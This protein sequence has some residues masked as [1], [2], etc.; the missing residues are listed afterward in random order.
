MRKTALIVTLAL[1]VLTAATMA[2]AAIAPGTT[3]AGPPAKEI[4]KL[5]QRIAKLE[6]E[7][8]KLRAASPAGVR[9]QLDTVKRVTDRFETVA[10]AAAA[11]Y[12]PGS[13]CEA[14]PGQGGMGF[15]YVNPAA[16]QDPKLD[17]LRPEALLYEQRTGGLQ[18]IGLEY[19]KVD[20]DQNLATDG[21]RPTPFNRAFD[22]PMLGH[23]PTMPIHYDL[24]VWLQKRN[25][26]GIF[27]QWNPEVS[28]K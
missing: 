15:H 28:C 6:A 1:A 12:V 4:A 26:S 22:G 3:A 18:L 11:G 24:H 14:I 2:G 23:S 9:K 8:A 13:P 27:A 19:M 7:L 20:G 17:P 21:D 10:A 16:I 25:P 5:K